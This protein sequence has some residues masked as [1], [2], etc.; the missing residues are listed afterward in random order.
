MKNSGAVAN[1][2]G[3]SQS[4][5]KRWVTACNMEIERN[6]HGHYLFTDENI[7]QLKQIQQQL[8]E[9][10]VLQQVEL[11]EKK[12]RK[13]AVNSTVQSPE[14]QIDIEKLLATV[15]ELERRLDD[16]AD[17]VASYQLLQHRR[18]I[19]D[20]NKQIERMAKRIEVLENGENNENGM[21]PLVFDEK[22]KQKKR[23]IF[24]LL[25]G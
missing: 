16:K 8:N 12:T 2:L 7:Q 5:V 22:K 24:Q 19:E 21:S 18:E 13:G 20:L 11:G 10:F 25:F 4:T 23:H 15:Q 6:S 17:S 1:E 3:I 9:G 14:S